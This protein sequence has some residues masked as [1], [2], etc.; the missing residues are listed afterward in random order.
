[1][2]SKV[3]RKRKKDFD[4]SRYTRAILKQLNPSLQL[5]DIAAN[6]LNEILRTVFECI[7][8]EAKT[9][10]TR[11]HKKTL[12]ADD[13][14]M[15]IK[16]ILRVKSTKLYECAEFESSIAVRICKASYHQKR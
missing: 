4:F 8:D 9:Q 12:A 16:I 3:Q 5:S 10:I 15:A 13:I 1:M 2:P 11:R 7:T 14:R 6:I